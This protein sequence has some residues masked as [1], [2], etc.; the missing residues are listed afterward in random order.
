MAAITRAN[1]NLGAGHLVTGTTTIY[2]TAIRLAVETTWLDLAPGGF[3]RIGRSKIDEV[4]KITC[5]PVGTFDAAIAA[6]LWPYGSAAV[7]TSVF[8]DADASCYIHTLSGQKWQFHSVAVTRMPTITLGGSTPIYGDFELTAIAKTGTAR[9]AANSIYT[10]SATAWSGTPSASSRY[11]L[12]LTS[13]TWAL[14]SPETI[15]PRDGWTIEF[16]VQMDPAV[17]A[18]T[19]T[20]D[21]YVRDVACR[22]RC[23]PINW[24][25]ARLDDL[26]L[27]GTGNDIGTGARVAADLTIIQPS[28]GATFVLQNASID[29][30]G[31]AFAD[32]EHRW[33]EVTWIGT[34]DVTAGGGALFSVAVTSA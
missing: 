5:T 4:V 23:L 29:V 10:V 22:A 33:P 6:F 15:I 32:N 25:D 16:D 31:A 11:T 14:T 19:G 2:C 27:Q 18:D 28:P 7:G 20:Y 3:G 34:R 26:K 30:A 13:S 9:S 1:R 8:G 12:P 21:M 17:G 24:T